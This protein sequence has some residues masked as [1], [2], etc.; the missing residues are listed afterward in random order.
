VLERLGYKVD[1]PEAQTCCG[2]MHF[3]SGYQLEVVH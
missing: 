1:F 2:P 3:N